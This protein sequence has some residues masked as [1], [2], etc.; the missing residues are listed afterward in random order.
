MGLQAP[1]FVILVLVTRI[2]AA[3]VASN[4]ADAGTAGGD[5]VPRNKPGNDGLVK[6]RRLPPSPNRP[7]PNHVMACP[8]AGHLWR[9]CAAI[10]GMD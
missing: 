5:G 1:H 2:P 9:P 3:N 10:D 6:S 7:A 8:H 4:E